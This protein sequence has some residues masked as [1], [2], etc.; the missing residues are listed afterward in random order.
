MEWLLEG[1]NFTTGDENATVQSCKS[2]PIFSIV[3][4]GQVVCTVIDW[5]ILKHTDSWSL[6]RWEC[7]EPY[8][9]LTVGFKRGGNA[10]LQAQRAKVKE[11]YIA[12]NTVA[13]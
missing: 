9:V 10:N 5:A 2:S 4:C 1:N 7:G 13:T 8:I 12:L 3:I 11:I 6:D